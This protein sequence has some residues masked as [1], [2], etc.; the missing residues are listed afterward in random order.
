VK[1]N[2]NNDVG[3]HCLVNFY[4]SVNNGSLRMFSQTF[5]GARYCVVIWYEYEYWPHK[6]TM[7]T[8]NVAWI[9]RCRSLLT[10]HITRYTNTVL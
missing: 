6:Q 5:T 10:R 4:N 3:C 9:R 1:V 8:E 7:S 2:I